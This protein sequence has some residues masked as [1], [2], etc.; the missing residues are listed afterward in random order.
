MWHEVELNRRQ[1]GIKFSVISWK[2]CKINKITKRWVNKI[3]KERI[4][5]QIYH[6]F[7]L[8]T[9]LIRCHVKVT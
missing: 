8:N 7:L 6:T 9:I 5:K 2:P 4:I 1:N 3:G